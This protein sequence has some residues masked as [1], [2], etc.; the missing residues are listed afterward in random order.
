MSCIWQPVIAVTV[1]L[2]AID[3]TALSVIAVELESKAELVATIAVAKVVHGTVDSPLRQL[4][5]VR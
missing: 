4:L 3:C 5:C 2:A 1:V